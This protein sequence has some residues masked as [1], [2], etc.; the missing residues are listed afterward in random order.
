VRCTARRPACLDCPLRTCCRAWPEIQTLL[1]SLPR[2]IQ[3][4]RAERFVG[5]T[6]YYR[7]RLIELLRRTPDS[8]GLDL[9]ALGERLRP[10]FS[11]DHLPWLRHLV[12]ELA[13]EGL[14]LAE[15]RTCDDA[16]D[17]RHVRVRLP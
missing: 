12:D 8:E 9:H 6:R 13:R 11:P 2:A 5:S 17:P 10:D 14:V 3:S 16:T 4:K 15:E 1:R 7:G